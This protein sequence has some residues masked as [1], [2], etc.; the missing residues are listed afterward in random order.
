LPKLSADDAQKYK[1]PIIINSHIELSVA[2]AQVLVRFEYANDEERAKLDATKANFCKIAG[3]FNY[4]WMPKILGWFYPG[5]PENY[6]RAYVQCFPAMA[7]IAV[8]MTA[9][10]RDVQGLGDFVQEILSYGDGVRVPA[11][12]CIPEAWK[13]GGSLSALLK[14]N[15]TAM[16]LSSPT[17]KVVA[18]NNVSEL[19]ENLSAPPSEWNR[20]FR[21]LL[22]KADLFSKVSFLEQKQGTPGQ[23]EACCKIKLG[24]W[25][26]VAAFSH[27][28]KGDPDFAEFRQ[29]P[30]AIWSHWLTHGLGADNVSLL[31]KRIS[32]KYLPRG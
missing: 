11:F 14:I 25:V 5:Y 21:K 23:A 30:F 6:R 10:R 3:D 9:L 17:L 19:L 31:L 13:H 1:S 24:A 22:E 32:F 8:Y 2:I 26:S 12:E 15:S 16:G 29:H 4:P 18:Y 20:I 7:R 28:A 27:Y